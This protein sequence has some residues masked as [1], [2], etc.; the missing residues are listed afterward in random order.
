MYM[1]TIISADL[2]KCLKLG[3]LFLFRVG[4]FFFIVMNYVFGNMAAVDT[5]LW[6]RALFR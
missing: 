3:W 1:Y 5:F 4:A 6:D 2:I